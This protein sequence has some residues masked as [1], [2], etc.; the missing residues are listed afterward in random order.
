MG[1]LFEPHFR[2]F[3]AA[4]ARTGGPG[5]MGTLFPC[6]GGYPLPG[7]RRRAAEAQ[8][9]G[10]AASQSENDYAARVRR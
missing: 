1:T 6:A 2:P 8:S 4:N 9:L 7:G 5:P 3:S 10:A